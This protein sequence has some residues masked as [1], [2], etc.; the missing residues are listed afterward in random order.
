MNIDEILIT[1]KQVSDEVYKMKTERDQTSIDME[2][3]KKLLRIA[4]KYPITTH[5]LKECNEHIRLDYIAILISFFNVN[6]DEKLRLQRMLLIYRIIASFDNEI[7]I[8]EY[9]TRSMKLDYK[10]WDSFFTTLDSRTAFCFAVDIL[11]LGMYDVKSNKRRKFE[12]ISD[13]LQLLKIGRNEINKGASITKSIIEQNFEQL[14]QLI[15]PSDIMDYSYFLGYFENIPF[16]SIVNSIEYAKE[17]EGSI[18]VVN[19]IIS[20]CEDF[21]DL[22]EYEASDIYFKRCKFE[23]IRGIKSLNKRVVFEEC[24][25]DGNI[26]NIVE[27]RNMHEYLYTECEENY[28]F[29][30]GNNFSFNKSRFINCKVSKHLLNISGSQLTECEFINCLGKELPCSY[31]FRLNESKVKNSKFID[32]GIETNRKD[33]KNTFGGLVLTKSSNIQECV[34][35]NCKSYGNSSYGSYANYNMQIVCLINSKISD[36]IFEGCCCSSCDSSNKTVTNYIIGLKE[37]KEENNEF[38]ECESYHYIYSDLISSHN[39]GNIE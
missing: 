35:D 36:C 39:V 1:L 31:L 2:Q 26:F 16:T 24:L 4:K 37:S 21:I 28:V 6:D 38:I 20:N 29:I 27:H 33:R 10:C 32:C 25:F 11:L 12:E 15:E 23:F 7:D 9:V 18:L 13:I 30:E 17:I 22:C 8:V 19:A 3:E 34:F 14:L 5:I